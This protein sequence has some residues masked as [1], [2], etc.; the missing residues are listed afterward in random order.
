VGNSFAPWLSIYGTAAASGNSINLQMQQGYL[1][2][3]QYQ[4]YLYGGVA[5]G[6]VG[7]A[8]SV[9]ATPKAPAGPESALAWLDRRVNEMRVRL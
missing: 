3:Q 2:Q 7:P 9:Q 6:V 4:Q 5:G 1:M 8:M